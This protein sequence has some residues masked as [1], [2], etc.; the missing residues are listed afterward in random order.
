MTSLQTAYGQHICFLIVG[1]L[2]KRQSHYSGC[3]A[4][5]TDICADFPA[6]VKVDIPASVHIFQLK[7][8]GSEEADLFHRSED[9]GESRMFQGIVVQNGEHVCDAE[10]VVC[11]ESRAPGPEEIP[12]HVKIQ[13][14]LL[15]IVLNAL[16][17]LIHHVGVRLKYEDRSIFVTGRS[18]L[19]HYD[20][21]HLILFICKTA[22]LC[23]SRDII[24]DGL[25]VAGSSRDPG[26]LIEK[27][28]LF[29]AKIE[30]HDVLLMSKYILFVF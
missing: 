9:A 1:F 7:V 25:L 2:L 23:E 17:L 18:G 12:V 10:P 14:I 21:P 16:V 5:R 22:L 11:A 24:A 27:E 3:S 13:R 20:V 4:G 26:D 15:E 28:T 6:R 19:V 30:I 29:F 8:P